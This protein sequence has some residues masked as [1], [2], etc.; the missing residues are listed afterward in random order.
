[1]VAK[2]LLLIESTNKCGVFISML[3]KMNFCF[4]FV[5]KKC[6]MI[7]LIRHAESVGNAGGRTASPSDNPLTEKG[8]RQSVELLKRLPE[9]PDLIVVSPY[10]RARQ[11]ARPL[12]EKYPDVPVEVW[13]VQEYTYLDVERCK[14]TTKAERIVIAGEYIARNDPDYIHGRGAESFNQ[15][16]QRVDE[17]FDRLKNMDNG[18][19]VILFTHRQFMRA[20]LARKNGNTVTFDDV[21]DGIDVDNTEIIEL[22]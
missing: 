7:Y 11:T 19:R 16:L 3:F 14:N 10:I 22:Q 5:V 17:M 15:M 13:N 9:K 21:F 6:N 8:I 18:K 2:V 4:I 20:A 1:L 12:I